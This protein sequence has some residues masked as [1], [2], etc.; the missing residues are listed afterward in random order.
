[1]RRVAT[2]ARPHRRT[3][4]VFLVLATVAAVLGVATPLL[5]GMA[6]DAIV[7]GGDDRHRGRRLAVAHRRRRAGRHRRRAARAAA[8]VA[9]RRGPDPRPAP[10]GVR[11]RPAHADRVLHPD[12]H[13]ARSSA[14]STTTSSAPSGR[15]PRRCP[16]SS[17][18]SSPWS[19]T[20][21]VMLG[22]VVA[23]HAA[24]AGA[25]A[26]LR[27]PGP[28]GRRQGRAARARGVRPQRG[29]DVADDRAVL[30]ARRDAREAVRPAGRGG[31]RVRPAGGA[32]AA[33]SACARRWR[34]RS[35]SAR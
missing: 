6:V 21:G 29:D 16:A 26:D 30:G 2:F 11:A 27:D 13:R 32:R 24:G 7:D 34:S 10:R 22:A 35:S 33:T 23:D 25:A 17:P 5:A 4:V 31:R 19:L 14:G 28:P 8:I 1:M 15:S 20:L 9:A 3:I 18:T 12:P